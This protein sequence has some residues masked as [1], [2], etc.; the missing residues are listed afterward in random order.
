MKLDVS[1][2]RSL[3][4]VERPDGKYVRVGYVKRATP[5]AGLL[6]RM[7][8]VRQGLWK[9]PVVK[10]IVIATAMAVLANIIVLALQ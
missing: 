9:R 4:I 7:D 2:I 3:E 8:G 10:T 5:G 1:Q 6:S